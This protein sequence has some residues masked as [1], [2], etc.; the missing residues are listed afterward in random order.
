MIDDRPPVETD[1]SVRVEDGP[2]DV[3]QNPADDY[4]EAVS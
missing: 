1:N 4:S 3:T 2:Q